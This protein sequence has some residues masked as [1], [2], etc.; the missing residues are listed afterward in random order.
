MLSA[1]RAGEMNYR[2]SG[3]IN[4]TK[5]T[6]DAFIGAKLTQNLVFSSCKQLMVSISN[7]K[8]SA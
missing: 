6:K 8:V 1:K 5:T 4:T 7:S 2:L 3:S